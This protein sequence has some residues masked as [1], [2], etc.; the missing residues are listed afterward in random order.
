MCIKQIVIS[1]PWGSTPEKTCPRGLI[2][3]SQTLI[4]YMYENPGL[5]DKCACYEFIVFQFQIHLSSKFIF[6]LQ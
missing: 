6:A 5:Y 4:L 3:E 1:Y 2:S